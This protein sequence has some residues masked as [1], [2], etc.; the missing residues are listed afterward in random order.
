MCASKKN[1]QKSSTKSRSHTFPP[2]I[3]KTRIPRKWHRRN[4][5]KMQFRD[6]TR[7][8]RHKKGRNFAKASTRIFT[9]MHT[10]EN[11]AVSTASCEHA[12]KHSPF[13][14]RPPLHTHWSLVLSSTGSRFYRVHGRSRK[15]EHAVERVRRAVASQRPC[16]SKA[17]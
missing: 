16:S 10:H 2:V 3:T 5:K 6:K 1:S 9:C 7:C 11:T 17:R 15:R 4:Q 13:T 12:C 14:N 8:L